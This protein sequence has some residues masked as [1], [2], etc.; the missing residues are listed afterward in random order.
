MLKYA[1]VM[2]A[3]ILFIFWCY[4][5]IEGFETPPTVEEM[6]KLRNKIDNNPCYYANTTYSAIHQK[7]TN[8][9]PIEYYNLMKRDDVAACLQKST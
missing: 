4:P 3:I 5:K 1:F 7:N 2:G 9:G 6:K 8:I